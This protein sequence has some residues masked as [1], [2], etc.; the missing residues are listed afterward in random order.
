MGVRQ[1]LVA[2][3]L[4]AVYAGTGASV[5]DCANNCF[6]TAVNENACD[7]WLS[8]ADCCKSNDFLSSIASCIS[9]QCSQQPAEEAWAH[10]AEQCDKSD[11]DIPSHYTDSIPRS[12]SS[13]STETTSTSGTSTASVSTATT[14]AAS[15]PASTTTSA[16]RALPTKPPST[17]TPTTGPTATP[18]PGGSDGSDA[19][20]DDDGGGG[21]N[22]SVKVVII[23]PLVILALVIPLLLFLHRRR[24][25]ATPSSI[26]AQDNAAH[27]NKPLV[28]EISG[29]EI[30]SRNG[31]YKYAA[32]L[33]A[34][35]ITRPAAGTTL[36]LPN[37]NMTSHPP[38]MGSHTHTNLESRAEQGGDQAAGASH[39]NFANPQP[40]PST[41]GTPTPETIPLACSPP[42]TSPLSHSS[43]P[44]SP[45]QAGSD[46]FSS[47]Q[48][49]L[50]EP[51]LDMSLEETRELQRLLLSLEAVE[52]R[53]R[54][55]A[56]RAR[57]LEQEEAAVRAEEEAL[58][59]EIRRRTGNLTSGR[60]S[61]RPGPS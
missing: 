41:L 1:A 58:L 16:T 17:G 6:Q 38:Y 8:D 35:E 26:E 3:V 15:T 19:S 24:K 54:E 46:T 14:T 29:T 52:R 60:V 25:K 45:I 59:E 2:T 28:H 20:N 18:A 12:T 32:E 55:S 43:Q 51:S 7:R 57:M 31:G 30:N 39:T 56:T 42:P 4:I 5:A 50:I 47:Q 37:S 21:L 10:L 40:N 33:E 61:P 48:L 27:E 23:V 49:S 36:P 22:A 34:V 53:K 9:E 13:R 44:V 11:I